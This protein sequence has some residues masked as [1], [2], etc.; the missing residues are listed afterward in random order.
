MCGSGR[1]DLI[2][3]PKSSLPTILLLVSVAT[4][5]PSRNVLILHE[6]SLLL[7]YQ[8]IVSEELQKGLASKRNLAVEVFEEYLDTWRLNDD[9]SRLALA[10]DTKYF[11]RRF[12]VVVAYGAAVFELLL[13][14]PP[15]FLQGT[16][17]V[18]LTMSDIHLPQLLPPNITGVVTHVD[19][20]G[21][22][23]LA[24]TLQPELQHVYYIESDP[25]FSVVAGDMLKG[26]FDPF[27]DK[28]EITIWSHIGLLELLKRVSNLP[29]HSAVLLDAYAQDPDGQGY[30]PA[31]VCSLLAA[32]SNS[33]V[34]VPYQTMIG[35]GAVAGV[36]ANFGSIAHQA[37]RIILALLKGGKISDFPVERSRNEVMVDWRQFE[38]FRLPERSLPSS[39]IVLYREP[40]VWQRYRWYIV[41]G[42]VVM[43]L[44]LALILKLVVEAKRRKLSEAS[45][46]ELAGR[47]IHAQ[48]KER[49]RIARELHDDLSQRLAWTCIQLDAMRE[50]P[51][52]EKILKQKLTDLYDETD[53]ICSDIH[54][55]SHE[56]HSTIL[57]KLGLIPALHR[58][59][60]EFSLHR[61]IVID[62]SVNGEE[63]SLN[64]EIALVIF[65]VAQEC[66]ANVAKHS[67]AASC[68]L[69]LDCM[70]D[71]LKLTVS[72]KGKSFDPAELNGTGGLGLESMRERLRSVKG[73]LHI[74]AAR[75]Q[76][77]TI[78]A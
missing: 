14:N 9:K 75:F 50:S 18:F 23:R 29:P 3:K 36:V 20:A 74:D 38:R 26:E 44:Q 55:I 65:R 73:A 51:P 2:L 33:P 54:Q 77:T 12:D 56:L 64:K 71:R 8:A 66:L 24:M 46:R 59:C 21:T 22:I 62:M 76:G 16:P 7:P 58:Y 34:Y 11:Q 68:Q 42:G 49:R 30:I 41:L 61:K 13:H 53:L 47:L 4:A 28:L 25:V 40:S 10:L 27:R 70:R 45:T 35:K 78:R 1:G 67:G 31:Q 60:E 37:N 17:V 72:D 32:S 69:K 6:G 19:Y 57:E 63:P 5:A 43:M 52:S 48:E 15:K 39:A